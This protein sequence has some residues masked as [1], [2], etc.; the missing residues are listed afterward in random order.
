MEKRKSH[1]SKSEEPGRVL[2]KQAVQ[3]PAES[4]G[5]LKF[6]VWGFAYFQLHH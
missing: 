3:H 2:Q 5:A 6:D 1:V 4:G